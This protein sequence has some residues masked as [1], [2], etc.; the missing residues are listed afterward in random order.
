MQTLCQDLLYGVRMLIGIVFIL[1]CGI[2]A[3]GG[4]QTTD[5]VVKKQPFTFEELRKI[6]QEID[7]R[8][9]AARERGNTLTLLDTLRALE[10]EYAAKGPAAQAAIAVR[11]LTVAPEV[12]NYVEALRYA[13]LAYGTHAMGR[14][15]NEAEL[16]GYQPVYAPSALALAAEAAQ[17][18]M[19]NE[20]HHVPQ[21]RAFTIEL[22]KLLRQ[23][24][25]SH[26][27]TETLYETD[28]QLNERGYPTAQTGYY[29]GEPVYG[30]L[31]RTALRLGY[32]V[33]PYEVQ[34]AT[35]SDEREQGQ[36]RNLIERILKGAPQARILVHA[37]YSHIDE[38]GTDRVGAMTMA[39]RFKE[40]T[41][42]DPF[43]IDQNEM[44]EHSAREFEHPL[45]RYVM[46]HRRISRPSVFRNAEGQ[47][48]TL[49]RGRNDVTVFHPRSRYSGGRPDWLR[50]GGSRIPYRLP[51]K[52][53]GSAQRC[54]V[55]ARITSE[56]SDAI[57]I[58]QL[59]VSA[60][61][62]APALMLPAGEFIVEVQDPKGNPIMNFHIR[63]GR[64]Q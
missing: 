61:R 23:K 36:A 3:T 51:K 2:L 56:G 40:A 29:T 49:E 60:S 55:R 42:I 17:V 20:G 11:I 26:F 64:R 33:V 13:D 37:G 54:L 16:K 4:Q 18:V 50:L 28:T 1:L 10:G 41:G 22:L 34:G 59:E 6:V 5:T 43:T 46:E 19:I 62:P 24:G 14:L 57:P 32:R 52:I 63:K 58:D 7:K 9:V 47:W 21:H 27:A 48:W 31:I 38:S 45:Y 12:G 25:F 44:T 30:H 15:A 8:M 35:N 53:C 39:Q